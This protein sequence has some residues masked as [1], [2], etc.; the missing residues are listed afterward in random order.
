MMF[1]YSFAFER[2][3]K[4]LKRF[5]NSLVNGLGAKKLFLL[6]GRTK[7]DAEA[8]ILLLIA[9]IRQLLHQQSATVLT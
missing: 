6:L 3:L 4:T 9:V 7:N 1:F 5:E 2:L 8:R